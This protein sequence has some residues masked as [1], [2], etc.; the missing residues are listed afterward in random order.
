M[1][2]RTILPG[3]NRTIHMDPH[4][5]FPRSPDQDGILQHRSVHLISRATVSF[6]LVVDKDDVPVSFPLGA[7]G[8][9][10]FENERSSSRIV[11]VFAPLVC[12]KDLC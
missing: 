9:A 7:D 11:S 4:G 3:V 8:N 10:Q 6:C 1:E 2:L 12:M 5:C